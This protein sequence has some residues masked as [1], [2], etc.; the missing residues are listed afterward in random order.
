M[1]NTA[2]EPDEDS[3][4]TPPDLED[5]PA[6]EEE[7][8][9][10]RDE[11]EPEPEPEPEQ[12]PAPQGPTEKELEARFKKADQAM[13]TYARRIGDI[14]G[15]DAVNLI[16]CPLCPSMHK[17]FLNKYDAGR[18][19]KE[20]MNATMMFLGYAQEAEYKQSARFHTCDACGGLG[21]VKSGSRVAQWE[22]LTCQVCRGYGYEPPPGDL[23]NGLVTAAPL[24][25]AEHIEPSGA[26][27]PDVDP[28]GEPRLLPDGRE[29]PNYGKWPQ[30]KI[31]VEPW[32]VTANLTAQDA[33]T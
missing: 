25:P 22:T 18:V 10:S 21:K 7:E 29:N 27:V 24:A 12:A 5:G 16:E 4:F 30:Y 20:E 9:A 31:R 3:P 15:D 2:H 8:R 23:G 17:G 28:S 1:S 13:A 19:P 11:K 26:G 33:V 6:D 32:G 14:Y